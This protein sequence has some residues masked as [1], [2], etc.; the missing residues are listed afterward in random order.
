MR[1]AAAQYPVDF[2]HSWDEFQR[3]LTHWYA[4]ADADVLV[5]PEYAAMELTSLLPPSTAADLHAS[6]EGLQ[7]LLPDYL[8]LHQSLASQHGVY[9]LVGS[10]PLKQD[11]RYLNQC[12]LLSPD[13][14]VLTQNK[15]IMTRFERE[16]WNIGGDSTLVTAEIEGVRVG[17]LICYD[18]EFPH[19]GRLLAEAGVE[20]LLVPSC[21]DTHAG[22][23]RV[24]TG[25]L[26]RALENQLIVVQSPLVG[27]AAWSP[28]IDE[29]RGAAGIYG[30]S[31]RGF[32]SNGVIAEGT[33]DQAQWVY[34]DID[35]VSIKSVRKEGQVL[36]YEHWPE[37]FSV[38]VTQY[39]NNPSMG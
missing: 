29:N 7:A 16:Q 35:P 33:L 5:F 8:A 20:V 9:S 25:C 12:Q 13:G 38:H 10:Y 32:P 22:Y 6:I 2:H 37:Q 18:S 23:H 1:I 26:A 30:P 19:L 24:R 36:N 14:S 21:T 11:Q 34:A 28:A 31:D 4:T 15:C 17:V 27:D 3:K 39:P